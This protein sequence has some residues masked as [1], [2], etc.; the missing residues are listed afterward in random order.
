[1]NREGKNG[2]RIPRSKKKAREEEAE[3]SINFQADCAA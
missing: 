1:M 3:V 2:Y